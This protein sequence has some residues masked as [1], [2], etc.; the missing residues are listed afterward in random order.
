MQVCGKMYQWISHYL[1]NRTAR[2]KVQGQTSKQMILEQGVPQGGVLSPTLFLVYINDISKNFPAKVHTSSF[3]DDLA[4]WTSEEYISIANN[5]MQKA[6]SVLEEWSKTWLVNISEE[7]T[8]CTVFSLSN[9]KQLAKLQLNGK[10][11]RQEENPKY[12]GITFDR[13]L[14]WKTQVEAGKKRAKQRMAIMK[15]LSG[16]TWGADE[17]VLKKLYTGRVRPVL[18]YGIAAWATA[19]KSNFNKIS[20]VQNQ[21]MRI[22]TG[23]M[24]TTPINE[25]EKIT[26]LQLMQDRRD[27][28][29]Q[30]QAEKFRRLT[31][32]PMYERFNGFGNGRLKRNNFVETAKQKISA[33]PILNVSTSK[34]IRIAHRF[35]AWRQQH[36]PEMIEN[37][38][39]IEK[40]NTQN[41]TERRKTTLNY[42]EEYY[43]S[44][45]WTHAY[46]DGSAK[47][48]IENGGG[49]IVL[50]LKNGEQRKHT[51][52][53]LENSQVI[54]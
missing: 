15:K 41:E 6:L 44:S 20:R 47:N 45:T 54:L 51:H 24:K 43:P 12:L 22:I 34:P 16:T 33:D 3:A 7:K 26:G 50:N 53:Q 52:L 32:H 27:N 21:G 35:P 17:K 18:E 49:G 28:K 31:D 23:G 39:G 29:A 1:E 9:K 4:I 11:L 10:I 19:A 42:I 36:L 8:T 30:Q 40:K 14:T 37:I 13:G 25:L 38:P 46:T 5:R 48:A 2:T